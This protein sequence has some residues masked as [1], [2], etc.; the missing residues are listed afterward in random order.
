MLIVVIPQID[1]RFLSEIQLDVLSYNGFGAWVDFSYGYLW[2]VGWLL[3]GSW[4]LCSFGIFFFKN[5]ARIS[6]FVLLIISALLIPLEGMS[7]QTSYDVFLS[8]TSTI[9]DGAIVTFA[10][11]SGV[12]EKFS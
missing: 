7:I 2:T 12:R 3:T 11:F 4:F 1:S 5:W 9:L 10:Y 6:Y 8:Y